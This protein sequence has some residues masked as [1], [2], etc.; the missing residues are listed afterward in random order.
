MGQGQAEGALSY[1]IIFLKLKRKH[2]SEQTLTLLSRRQTRLAH[3]PRS[4]RHVGVICHHRCW[5]GQ[6][7]ANGLTLLAVL[8]KLAPLPGDRQAG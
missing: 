6:A 7:R 1:Y 5:H 4:D 2:F 8:N 3:V